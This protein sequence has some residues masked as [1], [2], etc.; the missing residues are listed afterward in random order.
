MALLCNVA[1]AQPAVSDA[2]TNGKWAENTTWFQL[3]LRNGRVVRADVLTGE[4]Y[5]ALTNTTTTNGDAGL[6]CIVGNANDGYKFY[7]RAKGTDVFLGMKGDEGNGLAVFVDANTTGYT[8]AF[9]FV[10]SSTANHWCVKD[11]GSSNK[12][13]NYRSPRLAYWANNSAKG[14][15]GSDF[16]FT[17]VDL[18]TITGL[19]TEE[20]I[21][22][23]Q[24]WIKVAPG[25]PKTTSAQ[26]HMLNVMVNSVGKG[27]VA[28]EL[29]SAVT[30]YKTCSDVIL[31]EN[32]KAYTFMNVMGNTDRTKRYMKYE[33][34]TKVSVSTNES[35]ASVFV[36]R[37]LRAGVYAFVTTDG[38]VLTWVGNN[39]ANAYKENNNIYGYSSHY[40]AVYDETSDWNEI[41]ME[42]Y[43]A[44]ENNFGHFHLYARRKKG[45]VS[46]L[47]VKHSENRFDQSDNTK[48]FGDDF[49][50][51]WILTEVEHT[52]T[53][54]QTAALAEI[55]ATV[56]T[57]AHVDANASKL[58]EGIGYAHY[59]LG[60]TKS[61]DAAAVKTAINNA[62]TAEAVNAI[63]N[64]FKY[65][66]PAAGVAYYL[67]DAAH[68]VYLDIH[69]LGAES[70]YPAVNQ[71][72]TLNS[73]PQ[74]LYITANPANGSWKIHTTVKGGSYLCQYTGGKQTWD[75]WVSSDAADYSWSVEVSV[76]GDNLYYV[77]KNTGSA[78]G[79][80][81]CDDHANGKVLYA[82]QTD[83]NK[84]LKLQLVEVP[85]VKPSVMVY[86]PTT[87]ATTLT[88]GK[89]YMIYN[90]AF[91]NTE[92][93]TGFLYDNGSGMGHSGAPKKKPATFK[94][95]QDAY[96]WEIET[97]DEDGKYYLKAADGTYVNVSGNNGNAEPVAL[98]I[99]PWNTST[100]DKAGVKSEG[101]D[102]AVIENANIGADVFTISGTKQG[103]TGKDCWNG[104][105]NG[106]SMWESAHP[107]AFY[108][109]EE[110]KVTF[111]EGFP[112]P[113]HTYYIYCDNDKRQYFYNDGG[114]LKVSEKRTEWSNEYLF[115]CSFDGQYFQF[116][117]MKGK[118]LKHQGLQDA[119]YNFELAAYLD[120]VNLKTPGGKYFVMN[121]D[122]SFS[123]ADR[124]D[125]DPANTDYSTVYKFEEFNFPVDGEVYYI[126]SDTYQSGAYVN[127][128]LYADGSSLK[129]N[130]SLSLGS[131]YQWTCKVTDDGKVQFQNGAGKYLAHKGIQDTPYN[132]TLNKYNANHAIAA[133]LYSDAASR[134]FVVKNDGTSFDQADRTYNQ[135][136]ESHC[137][138][139]VFMPVSDVKVLS[140]RR[141][142]KVTAT[143]TWNGETKS[144]PASWTILPNTIINDPMLSIDCR[145]GFEFVGLY[146]GEESLGETVDMTTLLD[147]SRT[148]TAKFNLAIF[149]NQVGDKWINIVRKA[150]AKHAMF[151]GSADADAKPTFNT[152]DYANVGMMWSFV[153]TAD[154]FKIYN[155]VS[156]NK[157]ALTPSA[158]SIG[159]GTEVKMVAADD[160]QSWHLI[161]KEGGYAIAPVGNNDKGLNSYGGDD[162]LGGNIKFY[163][164]GDDGTQWAFDLIDT[165]NLLTMDVTVDQVW[166]S[167]PRVAELTFN[168]D[169]NEAQ[170][171]ITQKVDAAKYY[172][173]KGAVFSLASMTYRGYDFNG[174]NGEETYES[175]TIPVGGLEIT[176]S[177][178][179]NDERTLFYTPRDG[180]PYRIPAIATAPN[181]D[182]FAIC[183]YRPCGND[184]GYGEVDLVCRVSSDN[185]VTWTDERTI[186]DGLGHINDGIW[187]MGFGDPAIVADR[188]SNKVL[189]MSVCGNVTC[190][191]GT[192]GAAEN[193]NPNRVSRLY[194][195]YNED[196]KEWE[197][198][199][200]EEVTYSVYPLF[201][202]SEGNVHVASLFIGA[203]KICQSRVVKKNQYYRLYCA[204]WAKRNSGDQHHNY[205][206]YSDDFG[207][208]W[209]LLGSLG[210]TNSPAPYGN[211][212]KCEE[213]P[214]GTVVLSSRKGSGRYFNLFTFNNEGKSEEDMYTTGSW[215]T[216]VSSNNVTGGLSFGGNDTNGE[217][218][219]VKAIRKSDGKI[220]DVMLQSVPTGSGRSDVAIFYKEMEY[221]EN[222]TNKYTPETFAQGWTE[223]IHVS[224]KGSCYSTMILQADGRLGFF[225][226][227][228]PGGYCMVYIPYT[229]EDVTGGA[230]SLYTVN[231]TIGQYGVGTFYASEA[232]QIP[233]GIKAYVAT[234]EPVME[235]GAGVITMSELE[236]IIPAHTGAVLRGDAATY[237]FIPSISYGAAVKD[238]MLVGF[239]AADN[240]ADS[241][242]A[243]TVA[244]DYTTYVLTVQNEKA[245]F[246]RKDADFKVYNNKAY[247]QV[248]DAVSANAL[249]IRIEGEQDDYTTEI[250]MPVAN[251]QQP[252]AIYDLTGCR[253]QKVQKGL[254]IVNGKKVWK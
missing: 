246:Y 154:E 250:V 32:G 170:T 97:T 181:G 173:P 44:S 185:G 233:E 193:E 176:A 243:V 205:V 229:I 66:V 35:D 171:R 21:T 207:Q 102:G 108:E 103:H 121:T 159:D 140:V 47:I 245:G 98:Y 223:G 58:G 57:I 216:C 16:F 160:A 62:T 75:S 192:Y 163:G 8:T 1:W 72:A 252:T 92:D 55:D 82:N 227:E 196:A 200:P 41:S 79:Y 10:E 139:F 29:A 85:A 232:M 110:D 238:N 197:Y 9:D 18:S 187:K 112:I 179:A 186:A 15:D 81:G 40:A 208:S 31:P 226:E 4:G 194:I 19:A 162:S 33:N 45:S 228:E 39:E 204:V 80:L 150:N 77:L 222:G 241:K 153:G 84:K 148:L 253:V 104:N 240:K 54:E 46:A 133:T 120:G 168:V 119:A 25:Y 136:T 118:Y 135:T 131:A 12:Y 30:A 141:N 210:Y 144:L 2:P 69:H 236:G 183:D 191:N 36:C 5:L 244:E 209:N 235:N 217:I 126:Y 38:K 224:T 90:T 113:G 59:M 94:T 164:T 157:L 7:N 202:D 199:A 70:N 123:Q 239:E 155:Y 201:K 219:K 95:V 14:N 129:L 230:Y 43:G 248:P 63:K 182:I 175:T 146:D 237:K 49:S 11:H 61:A 122:K 71:M 100:A 48:Y 203:G 99:Q 198:G 22:A 42:K 169:G 221:N 134:Y 64:S 132:F 225:F 165:E 23:A 93:R 145:E 28:N 89:K 147:K 24:A 242:K 249:R 213:L 67:Y 247:L 254:Y 26:Y 152:K 6:W 106:F 128:Y 114:T 13:W 68:K 52:N 76:D 109:V 231:S 137:T 189:V 125:Y 143:A 88:S 17:Q 211:E 188:E 180:H 218:Y 96:L 117:N 142:C 220:C 166:T 60:E 215:G 107:Y 195:T 50:S 151:L 115:T 86:R 206:I 53:A 51:A 87:R 74:A 178:T 111:E 177:Y 127:R 124:G 37:Q 184:I 20:E 174:F 214:D 149:S 3:K 156:G 251:G 130:T 91:H 83:E 105:P 65:E 167:S 27:V 190:H 161:V 138:D 34:G 101:A 172:L 212:P 56:E 116:K 73:E 234:E 158:A 78:G